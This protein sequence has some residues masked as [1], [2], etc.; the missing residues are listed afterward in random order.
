MRHVKLDRRG[1]QIKRFVRSLT[2]DP[3]GSVIELGGQALLHVYPATC[4][5]EPIDAR[6]VKAAILRRRDS[7]RRANADWE[8]VDIEGWERLGGGNA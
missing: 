2:A 1:Q 3:A 5:D 8:T 6:K 4:R 7:S